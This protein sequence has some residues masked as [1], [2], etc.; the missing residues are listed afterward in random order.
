MKV[1]G[2]KERDETMKV[3]QNLFTQRKKKTED[4]GWNEKRMNGKLRLEI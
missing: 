1:N 2:W 4:E 3:G